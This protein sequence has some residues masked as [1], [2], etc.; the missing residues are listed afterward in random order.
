M[1]QSRPPP[2]AF[3]VAATDCCG[4]NRQISTERKA[5]VEVLYLECIDVGDVGLDDGDVG[6]VAQLLGD[7]L[8]R[9]RL[10]TNNANDDVVLVR[11]QLAEIFPLAEAF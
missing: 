11:G 8:V 1:R 5:D 6:A 3:S 10:V 4:G 2:V 7:P 9:D